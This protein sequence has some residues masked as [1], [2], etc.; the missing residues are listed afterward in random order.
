MFSGGS[1]ELSEDLLDAMTEPLADPVARGD[2]E[3]LN[4]PA[5]NDNLGAHRAKETHVDAP[6]L[7]NRAWGLC[8]SCAPFTSSAGSGDAMR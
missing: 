3:G 1:P 6:N 4:A 7:L 8:T 2:G 5:P